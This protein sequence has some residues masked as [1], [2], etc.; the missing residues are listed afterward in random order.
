MKSGEYSRRLLGSDGFK[1]C[2]NDSATEVG[3]VCILMQKDV[4][5]THPVATSA[6]VFVKHMLGF[7]LPPAPSF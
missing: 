2:D 4:V 3:S 1:R 7:D 5:K 6:F